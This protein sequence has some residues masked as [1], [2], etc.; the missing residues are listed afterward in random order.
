MKFPD[1]P[2]AHFGARILHPLYNPEHI[3]GH[4]ACGRR[5]REEIPIL[6]K[7]VAIWDE[8][9]ALMAKALAATPPAKLEHA[10]KIAGVGKFFGHGLHTLLH[11]KRW[12]LLNKRLEI[13]WD[14]DKAGAIMDEL[15]A[16]ARDEIVNVKGAIPLVEADSRLGW[17][18]SMEY[19]ADK[20]HLEWKLRQL[21]NLIAHTMRAY[22]S[23]LRKAPPLFPL[24]DC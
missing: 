20:W 23:T 8:G 15:E 17:E 18:P 12:W 19:M 1:N 10:D 6:E 7:T 14:F 3:Y 2:A 11:V 13:E 24:R 9:S 21:E 22:R 16:I 5:I 4:T